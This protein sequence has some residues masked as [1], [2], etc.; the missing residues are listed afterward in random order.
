M[1]SMSPENIVAVQLDAY[2][3][4]DL[5][6]FCSVYADDCV[7]ALYGGAN[8]AEGLPA[9]RER[10][11]KLFADFPKNRATLISRRAIGNFV[12]DQEHVERAPD[13]EVFDVAA[14]YTIRNSQIARV[15]FVR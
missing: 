5:E 3:A 4:R 11:R 13:G 7:L 2:N 9:I 15:E 12:I 14:I 1:K 10:H 6:R 8:L